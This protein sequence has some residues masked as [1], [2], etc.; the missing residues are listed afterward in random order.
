M[1]NEQSSNNSEIKQTN[2][3]K[4][5]NVSIVGRMNSGKSSLLNVLLQSKSLLPVKA[6]RETSAIVKI[7]YHT[8][9]NPQLI[10]K[11]IFN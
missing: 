4:D 8:K 6:I 3:S 5:Y 7:K 2:P 11:L 9:I 10:I 1:G